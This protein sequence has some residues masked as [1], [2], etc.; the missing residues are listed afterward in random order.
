ME[1]NKVE[2]EFQRGKECRQEWAVSN[3]ALRPTAGL[4]DGATNG[5]NLV[6]G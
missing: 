1:R 3:P 5:T 4:K 2:G 6:I